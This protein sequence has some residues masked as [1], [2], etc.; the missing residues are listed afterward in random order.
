[1]AIKA[2]FETLTP[3]LVLTL[4]E[5]ALGKKCTNLCRPLNSYINRVYELELVDGSGVIAKFYRPGRWSLAALQ[6]EHDFLLELAEQ[7]M[8]VIAPLF[9]RDATTLG[10]H[11]SMHFAVFPKKS[12]RFSD[13]FTDEQWPI[14]G[15]LLGR[16][17]NIGATR[18]ASSRQILTPD[19]STRRQIDFMIQGEFIPSDLINGYSEITSTLINEITPLFINLELI[20]IHGDCHFGNVIYRP[21]E[22]FYLIDFDDMVMGPPVQDLW[23]LL[24]GHYQDALAETELFLEGYEIFRPFDYRSLELIEPLRAMRYIHFSAWCARQAADGGFER[25]SPDWGTRH[26]WRR[27]IEDLERQLGRIRQK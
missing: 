4:I 10:K 22:A 27:E 8:P 6:E 9:L 21:D 26:Y 23:M 7:E 5:N 18:K 11:D 13:E 25:L 20:R 19:Q 1:M 12:G 2:T 14:L 24:P 17:H 15:R 16:L 3:H